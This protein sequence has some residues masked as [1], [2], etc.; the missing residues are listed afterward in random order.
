M[1]ITAGMVI[2]SAAGHD[3]E[4]W[5]LV[6]GVDGRYA[7]LAD[8]KERKLAAPKKKNLKHI[9]YTGHSLEADGMTDKRLRTALRGLSQSIAEESE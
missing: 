5:F 2:I 9:R 8:G 3:K 4:Q 1:E 7:Y 6:T